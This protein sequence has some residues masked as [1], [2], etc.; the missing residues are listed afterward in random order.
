MDDFFGH[1]YVDTFRMFDERPAQ[2]SFWDQKSRAREIF[3]LIS[4]HAGVQFVETVDSGLIIATGDLRTVGCFQLACNPGTI[5]GPGDIIGLAGSTSMGAIAIMDNA[6]NW[7]SEY[8]GNWF[9]TAL[10]EI[11]H[12]NGMAHAYDL[13][14]MMGGA[15]SPSV[16]EAFPGNHDIVHLQYSMR[17]ES[18]DIDMYEFNTNSLILCL[19]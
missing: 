3:D 13:P 15:H 11:G 14:S 1:G 17:P 12:Q 16:E 10:H 19:Y 2:Y 9:T 18:N 6:E 4:E 5:S 8:G 7:N